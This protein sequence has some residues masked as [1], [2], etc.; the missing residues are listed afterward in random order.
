[1]LYYNIEGHMKFPDSMTKK[2]MNDLYE[3]YSDFIED[4]ETDYLGFL[5]DTYSI[6]VSFDMQAKD[7]MTALGLIKKYNGDI[8]EIQC[9]GY[10][11]ED[12]FKAKTLYDELLSAYDR[13]KDDVI[14][15]MKR[16]ITE[17][18]PRSEFLPDEGIIWICGN[19]ADNNN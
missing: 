16:M 7:L 1:M 14:E 19:D 2:Q 11:P 5:S 15:V 8:T 12:R 18:F 3:E 17:I 9:D 10:S 6:V 4:Y 13:G